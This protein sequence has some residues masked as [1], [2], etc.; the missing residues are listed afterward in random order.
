MWL[1]FEMLLVAH[2]R[3]LSQQAS[4]AEHSYETLASVQPMPLLL[5]QAFVPHVLLERNLREQQQQVLVLAKPK[6][7]GYATSLQLN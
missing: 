4:H 7:Q 6:L 1:Q 2:F 5:P 3:P